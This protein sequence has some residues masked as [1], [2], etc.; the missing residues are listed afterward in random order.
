ML[1][2]WIC[3]GVTLKSRSWQRI[4]QSSADFVAT[5][6]GYKLQKP[7]NAEGTTKHINIIKSYTPYCPINEGPIHHR[8]L[9]R[10]LQPRATQHQKT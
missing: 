2:V 5:K 8:T 9:E 3:Y 10:C 4:G 6:R 7:P 1:A